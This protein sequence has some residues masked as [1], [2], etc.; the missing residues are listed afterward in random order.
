MAGCSSSTTLPGVVG[1]AGGASAAAH[2]G[3]VVKVATVTKPPIHVQK[4]T[5]G[6]FAVEAKEESTAVRNVAVQV[7]V[8][9]LPIDGTLCQTN[10]STGQCLSA[11]GPSLEIN[12]RHNQVV[13][14]SVFLTATGSIS[15]GTVS[16]NFTDK[17]ALIGS[18]KVTVTTK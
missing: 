8:A 9:K 12:I 7:D 5:T 15:K 6:A 1:V 13:A 18:G 14:F 16:V 3:L 11:P 4:G 17:N 10:P 2:K